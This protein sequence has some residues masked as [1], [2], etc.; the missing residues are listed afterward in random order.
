MSARTSQLLIKACDAL[1][2]ENLVR[3]GDEA[4]VVIVATRDGELSVG[5]H[6][7]PPDKYGRAVDVGREMIELVVNRALDA[8]EG[9]APSREVLRT[10]SGKEFVLRDDSIPPPGPLFRCEACGE[11]VDE[12]HQAMSLPGI[13][14]D[15]NT[16]R[17]RMVCWSCLP[18]DE[19]DAR[20]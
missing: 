19:P 15:E 3:G 17:C 14:V 11:R 20:S 7:G 2:R 13:R 12:V 1:R 4:I 5:M 9:D 18:Y 8:L 10:E 6:A 16:M